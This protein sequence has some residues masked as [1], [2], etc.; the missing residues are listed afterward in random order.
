MRSSTEA[1][2]TSARPI[3]FFVALTTCVVVPPL[4]VLLR[5]KQ[6]PEDIPK[7]EPRATRSPKHPRCSNFVQQRFDLNLFVLRFPRVMACEDS[8]C[9]DS[10]DEWLKELLRIRKKDNAK[11]E[12]SDEDA[13]T[14][15]SSRKRSKINCLLMYLVLIKPSLIYKLLDTGIKLRH[16][17]SLTLYLRITV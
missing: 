17:F 15:L 1:D 14:L 13:I 3:R 6:D 10:D 9:D 16:L 5:P 2:P 12:Q 4:F 8:L 7:P 11:A